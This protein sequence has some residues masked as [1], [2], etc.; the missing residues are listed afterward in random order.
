MIRSPFLIAGAYPDKLKSNTRHSESGDWKDLSTPR[1]ILM[2]EFYLLLLS[3]M[4]E[5][6]ASAAENIFQP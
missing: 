3:T 4:S 1:E 5:G 2:A 6:N